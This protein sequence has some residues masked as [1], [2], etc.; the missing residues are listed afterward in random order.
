MSTFVARKDGS[1]EIYSHTAE[2]RTQKNAIDEKEMIIFKM[3]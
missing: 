1:L 2:E 3:L